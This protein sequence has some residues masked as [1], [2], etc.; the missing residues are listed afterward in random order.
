MKEWKMK[1]RSEFLKR[2]FWSLSDGFAIAGPL[3]LPFSAIL[4]L[5]LSAIGIK[6][7]SYRTDLIRTFF[8]LFISI[9]WIIFIKMKTEKE[10]VKRFSVEWWSRDRQL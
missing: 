6:D 9:S 2:L 7:H 5:F 8:V 10:K 1:K 4:Y 3:S